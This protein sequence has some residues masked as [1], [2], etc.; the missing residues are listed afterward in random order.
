M[1]SLEEMAQAHLSN[2]QKAIVDMENQRK[3]IDEEITKLNTY[4]QEG[5]KE[6]ESRNQGVTNNE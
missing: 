4:L 2:V 5:V 1:A 3:Q 6:L